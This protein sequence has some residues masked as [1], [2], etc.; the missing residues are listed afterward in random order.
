MPIGDMFE[1]SIQRSINGVIKADQKDDANVWQELDEYVI[2]KELDGHLRGFFERYLSALDNPAEASGNVGV[3]VSGF[4]GS[5]K[6]LSL[7]HI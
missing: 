7:I 3:W 1:R 4:F 6:S 2:T 5:G